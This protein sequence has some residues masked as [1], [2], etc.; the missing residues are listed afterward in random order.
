[1]N[2]WRKYSEV[3]KKE[4]DDSRKI[5][6]L[7]LLKFEAAKSILPKAQV[8][9]LQII[10]D[11]LKGVAKPT[12]TD[13][14]TAARLISN[15]ADALHDLSA[16]LHPHDEVA[17]ESEHRGMPEHISL[18]NRLDL[19]QCL[20]ATVDLHR[21]HTGWKISYKGVDK[22]QRPQIA[23]AVKER[24]AVGY[25]TAS[26]ASGLDRQGCVVKE[27]HAHTYAIH[28]LGSIIHS[29]DIHTLE[30]A[31]DYLPPNPTR[32]QKVFARMATGCD[33]TNS[34]E[35]IW[36]LEIPPRKTN[37]QLGVLDLESEAE[38]QRAEKAVFARKL[39]VGEKISVKEYLV[40]KPKFIPRK[41]AGPSKEQVG[42]LFSGTSSL[43]SSLHLP[44]TRYNP[45]QHVETSIV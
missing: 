4:Q 9:K 6:A 3:T 33:G 24:L 41:T 25:T 11:Y 27:T 29:N 30:R 17:S 43:Y 13:P 1:M 14:D 39:P 35:I 45:Q 2:L 38:K 20:Q 32:G 15:V 36:E 21:L 42:E 18:A 23:Q 34:Q 12:F 16:F 26:C 22:Q 8:E 40:S 37:E 28:T 7:N 5:V 44:A 31:S 10:I 19:I